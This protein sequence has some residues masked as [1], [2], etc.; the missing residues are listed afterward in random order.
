[1]AVKWGLQVGLLVFEVGAQ[2]EAGGSPKHHWPL[3]LTMTLG[4]STED[5]LRRLGL[6]PD[7]PCPPYA[8]A[9]AIWE[10]ALDLLR[11]PEN[12]SGYQEIY[13]VRNK[14]QAKPYTDA[15]EQVNLGSF[16]TPE[17]AA[18]ELLNFHMSGEPLLPKGAPRRKRGTAEQP[19]SR[20]SK[21]AALPA[22]RASQ[23]GAGWA[24]GAAS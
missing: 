15:G 23:H 5:I 1:L 4:W 12:K 10:R 11:K 17:H 14:W 21:S 13:R 8:E 24:P 16:D 18:I 2:T 6:P 20:P 22:A 3:P 7:M 19:R 9:E